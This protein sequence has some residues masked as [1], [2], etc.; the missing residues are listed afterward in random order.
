[1]ASMESAHDSIMRS[2]TD[3]L[4]QKAVFDRLF[5]ILDEPELNMGTDCPEKAAICLKN[6]DFAYT[7]ESGEGK[8]TLIKL[9]LGLNKA[10]AGQVLFEN[11]EISEIASHSLL[12]NV[13]AVMQE[14]MFFN[15]SIR[16]NLQL[17]A[18]EASE[19]DITCFVENKRIIK[20]A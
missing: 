13:G 6:I 15:L 20:N 9:L 14:N 5:K 12:K 7:E 19:E 2:K 1:M 18:P 16:E 10:Q 4:G 17:I 3:F 11:T 8:S